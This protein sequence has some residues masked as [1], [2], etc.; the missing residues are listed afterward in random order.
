MKPQ[1]LERFTSFVGRMAEI[2]GVSP[3]IAATRKFTVA[4]GPA[5]ARD[6]HA[7]NHRIPERDQYH[8]GR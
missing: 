5:D 3:D 1:T 6:A 2:N 4:L 8:S 7:G